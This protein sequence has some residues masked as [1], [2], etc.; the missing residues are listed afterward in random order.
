MHIPSQNHESGGQKHHSRPSIL[1]SQLYMTIPRFTLE[2]GQTLRNV[3]VAFTFHGLLNR[4]GD[5]AVVICHALSGN[6]AI[7]E[8][9][10]TLMSG[11]NPALDPNQYCIICCNVL[12][13][14]YG[15]S[16]PLTYRDANA[17]AKDCYGPSFPA[18]TI[19][20][21]VRAHRYVLDILGVKSLHCVIGPSMGGMT[22]L[23]WALL[24]GQDY[25][26]SLVLVATAAKQGA[27]QIACNENQRT[28]IRCDKNYRDGWYSHDKRPE[29]GLAAARMAALMTYRSYGSFEERFGRR[30]RTAPRQIKSAEN[31]TAKGCFGPKTTNAVTVSVSR[32]E[33]EGEKSEDEAK[34]S[35]DA[36]PQF[37]V[38]SYLQYHGDKF[39]AR[40]DA[41]CYVHILD[42]MDTHDVSR[43][44]CAPDL[45]GEDGAIGRAL[46]RIRQPTLVVGVPSDILYPIQEQQILFENIPNTVLGVIESRDGHD[47]F[48]IETEQLDGL[49]RDFF[50]KLRALELEAEARTRLES[51]QNSVILWASSF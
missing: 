10:P 15:S 13:S 43:G 32:V 17:K 14:P 42:K 8:W 39:N 27:W 29:A 7:E 44:R 35:R 46:A 16:S 28:S 11:S 38:Q 21:D 26:R 4:R 40:F 36:L 25:V 45:T 19:R 33:E 1:P 20:D 9:W 3:V 37:S 47:A 30:K 41:N 48:L 2:S 5:N 23:E 31:G 12:G 34:L 51:S 24:Y 6:A 50:G 49:V 18:T 22:A